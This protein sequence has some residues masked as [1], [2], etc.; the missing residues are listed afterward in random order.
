[1]NNTLSHPITI[2]SMTFGEFFGDQLLFREQT[3]DAPRR[4]GV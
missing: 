2:T 1:M 4:H 3:L